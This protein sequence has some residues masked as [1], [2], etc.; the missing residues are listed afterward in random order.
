MMQ[1]F[2][3]LLLTIVF[4]SR[5][6][7]CKKDDTP[8]CET[9]L[10]TFPQAFDEPFPYITSI[11]S[12]KYPPLK[13]I[14]HAIKYFHRKDLLTPFA[15]VLAKKLEDK[16]SYLLVPI[17]MPH[18]RKHLRGYNH[19]E[20]LAKL[21]AERSCL[22]LDRTLL[23]RK[24]NAKRQVATISR[25]DRINNQH[26]TFFVTK[27]LPSTK[28]ILIDDVTTTGATISS[29]RQELLRHGATCVEALTIAH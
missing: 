2:F 21:I 12:F 17:P 9:C 6:Y 7:L 24:N 3:T 16:E 14:I 10:Q 26:G 28:I 27:P 29:A 20:E 11:Y 18:T 13:K 15:N 4:P 8:L 19:A 1:R 23:L 25:R 22:Q 5:C